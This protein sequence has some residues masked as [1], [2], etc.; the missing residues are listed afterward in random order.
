MTGRVI[1]QQQDLL[2]RH[3]IPPPRGPGLQPGRDLRRGHPAV[4]SKLASAS[5][6]STGRWPRVWACNGRKNCPSGK[7]PA[8]RWAVCTAKVVLPIP[9]I[10]PIA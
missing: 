8:S 3:M 4:S 9:A 6:G 7:A 2:A 5:A 1:Q 10:P